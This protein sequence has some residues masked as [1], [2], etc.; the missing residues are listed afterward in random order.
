MQPLGCM[1]STEFFGI[2]LPRFSRRRLTTESHATGLVQRTKL[3][4][5]AS[6]PI[7]AGLPR[8]R[9]QFRRLCER[10]RLDEPRY[11][12]QQNR[13]SAQSLRLPFALALFRARQ[14]VV[15][16]L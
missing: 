6:P 16:D 12:R 1:S 13:R 3:T 15:K 9:N 8:L 2:V 14:F 5:P 4:A 7:H 11:A 10:P